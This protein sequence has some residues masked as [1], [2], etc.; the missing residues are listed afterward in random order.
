MRSALAALLLAGCVDTTGSALV[1]FHAAAAGPSDAT[2]VLE[3]D[4]SA[5]YH[6]TFTTAT[7]HIGGVYLRLKQPAAGSQTQPCILPG[8]NYSGEVLDGLDVN[9]LSAEPQPFPNLGEGT[10]DASPIGEVWLVNGPVDAD[11]DLTV[12]ARLAGTATKGATSIPFTAAFTISTDNRGIN[13]GN[14]AQPGA[15]PICKQRIVTPITAG[16]APSEGGTLVVRA[17]PRRW[18]TTTEFSDAPADPGVPGGVKFADDNTTNDP[19]K[20]LFSAVRAASTY[21]LSFAPAP[22]P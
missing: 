18:V 13:N 7:L 9:L 19:S 15:N 21:T 17:D 22:G 12:I 2:G 1:T 20:F 3:T 6:V 4:T 16:F 10:A 14:P 8:Q 11:T 5:G